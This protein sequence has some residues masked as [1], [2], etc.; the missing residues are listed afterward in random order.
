[1]QRTTSLSSIQ[2]NS[3]SLC[4]IWGYTGIL[5]GAVDFFLASERRPKFST[6][7]LFSYD[8]NSLRTETTRFG[9]NICHVPIQ[10]IYN[11][12]LKHIP[13]N[14][15]LPIDLG[16]LDASFSHF[17]IL[18][19]RASIVPYVSQLSRARFFYVM[20]SHFF[21]LL[22]GYRKI[23]IYFESCPHYPA[24][25]VLDICSSF[26][27]NASKVYSHDTTLSNYFL[28]TKNMEDK[29][30]PS[31]WIKLDDIAAKSNDI[32]LM[33]WL[34]SASKFVKR[35]IQSDSHNINTASTGS[36]S[37]FTEN[38]NSSSFW[39]S[40]LGPQQYLE[41]YSS[42]I[43][44]IASNASENSGWNSGLLMCGRPDASSVRELYRQYIFK[45]FEL[46]EYYGTI[47]L[48]PELI[49]EK[50]RSS[51]FVPLHYQPERST[52]PDGG[53]YFDQIRFIQEIRSKLN[54]KYPIL[55]KEH[56][57]QLVQSFPNPQCGLWRDKSFYRQILDIPNTYFVPLSISQHDL[58][59]RSR[60]VATVT[61]TSGWQALMLGKKCIFGGF[62]WYGAHHN[63]FGLGTIN[64][65]NDLMKQPDLA[66]VDG[67]CSAIVFFENIRHGLHRAGFVETE[68]A[69][70]LCKTTKAWGEAIITASNIS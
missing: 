17:N 1:M 43:D 67:L 20:K 46:L 70:S 61:G 58:L 4:I 62:P 16:C 49:Y 12:D 21:L 2:P 14:D 37:Q 10:S 35:T 25:Y 65:I 34:P 51:C 3:E 53:C 64:S 44:R 42:A 24:E 5:Q 9:E 57:T 66:P 54:H 28:M 36:L 26:H 56:P 6:I 33:D 59:F 29:L 45:S 30:N 69:D 40:S 39:L 32:S 22:Q 52:F 38:L 15:T 7:Y 8:P 48:S 50:A 19:D 60:L 68:N 18:C 41:R 11:L 63:S 47:C 31:E 55:V 27:P 13:S 23:F